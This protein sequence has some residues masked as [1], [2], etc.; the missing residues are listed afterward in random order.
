M[1]IQ[2]LVNL[3]LYRTKFI[4]EDFIGS[5]NIFALVKSGSFV[6]ESADGRHIVGA[7]EGAL[8]RKNVLYHREV[9]EPVDMHF[10]RY[11]SDSP[12]FCSDHIEFAD[13]DRI[14]STISM[15]EKLEYAAFKDEFEYRKN[16]FYDIITQYSL[17]N[18]IFISQ[19]QKRD[20]AI[21]EAIAIISKGLHNKIVLSEIA[22]RTDLSYVQFLRR[23]KAYTG[24]SPMEYIN[25]LRLQ[26][27]KS[28]LSNSELLIREI[29][30]VCGFE[31]EYYFSNF[32]KKHMNM[33]PTSY[34]NLAK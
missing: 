29:A 25:V 2:L 24:M 31:D 10:F 23:F 15:L 33:S 13:K 30:S 14:K 34:R 7:N 9:I 17:E 26:K 32:F 3:R 4:M 21:D 5:H 19:K 6:F 12:V 11:K 16:L 27:A 1:D 20:A 28:L 22:G 18:N 8:F